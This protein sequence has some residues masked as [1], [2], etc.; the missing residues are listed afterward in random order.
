MWSA[1]AGRRPARSPELASSWHDEDSAELSE[2]GSK[3]KAFAR[4]S[5]SM[6][7]LLVQSVKLHSL[8]GGG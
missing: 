1:R 3:V 4:P 7:T 2:V 8:H 6:T 5:F